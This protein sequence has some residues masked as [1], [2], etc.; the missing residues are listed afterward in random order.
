VGL[1]PTAGNIVQ[2][3]RMDK[4]LD[5]IRVLDFSRFKAGP[6]CG[7]ILAD[8][9]AEVIRVERPG[10]DF[11]RELAPFTPEGQSFYLA[12]T[13]RNK[14][15]I[16][17]NLSEG[18]GKEILGKLV[19]Q[20]DVVLESFDPVVKKKL[21]LD[22]QSLKGIKQ[23]IIVVA[24]SAYGQSGPYADRMGFDAIVQGVSGLMWVTGFPEGKPVRLGVSFV[25]V[26]AGIYGALGVSLA[27]RYRD[28]TGQG[29]LIDVSLLDVAVSFMESIFGEYM[30][31]GQ[32]RPQVGNA[33]VLA[34][35]YDAFKAKDGW[36][37][38]GT[39]TPGQWKALCQATGR[40]ELADD[41]RFKTV[42]D[43]VRPESRHFFTQW[44]GEWVADKTVDELVSQLNQAGVSAGRVNTVPEV[45]SN[46][47]IQA[48]R[49]VVELDHPNIGEIPLLGVPIKLS[50]TPGQ[51][52]TPAP[53]VGEHNK[54]I[55]GKLLGLSSEQL[56]QL[57]EQG[58]I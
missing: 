45:I 16:T 19:Q 40:E 41:P 52:R 38:I 13:C 36:V 12:Y 34:A 51:I 30:V 25:D 24:V 23:D 29:Q 9:G 58:V 11:D 10:G 55:Y 39:A 31:A 54:Q 21:G 43:R 35:P 42:R 33:N 56:S 20:T 27:L 4:V 47:Q 2:E 8:M 46:P 22:Y 28:K 44:L 50:E 1:S 6:T 26:A 3:V 17:L 32:I 49:M 37:S 57:R 48:R 18:K 14:K 7:Q 53:Q 15:G 5:G